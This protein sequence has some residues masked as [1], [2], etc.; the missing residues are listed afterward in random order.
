MPNG[1][2]NPVSFYIQKY[3]KSIIIL[4][5]WRTCTCLQVGFKQNMVNHIYKFVN[6][7]IEAYIW[8]VRLW[9]F[10]KWNNKKCSGINRNVLVRYLDEF[11]W[12]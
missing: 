2:E 3:I 8:N 5:C 9:N 7:D 1:L 11:T 4:V 6:P 12:T 10:V